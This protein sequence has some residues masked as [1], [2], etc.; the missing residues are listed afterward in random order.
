MRIA[1]SVDGR[2]ALDSFTTVFSFF[3]VAAADGE[4]PLQ[5]RTMIGTGDRLVGIGDRLLQI[6]RQTLT[7]RDDLRP[8]RDELVVPHIQRAQSFAADTASSG[9]LQQRI[10]LFEHTVVVGEDGREP[11]S[12]LD[13]ELIGEAAASRGVAAHDLQIFR[14]EQHHM[15]VAGEFVR[16]RGRAVDASLVRSLPVH[17]DL[18]E[19]ATLAVRESRADHCELL[20][21]TDHRRIRGDTVR[22]ERREENDGLGEIRLPLTV[23]PDEDVRSAMQGEFSGRVIAEIDQTQV[24]H[25]HGVSLPSGSDTGSSLVFMWGAGDDAP[26]ARRTGSLPMLIPGSPHLPK[27]LRERQG[28]GRSG[29]VSGREV[30]ERISAGAGWAE[31]GT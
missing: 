24:L 16:L 31:A 23:A 2:S 29:N 15:C 27:D 26:L 25:N 14:S 3:G 7:C 30:A 21:V 10:A 28:A 22:S 11:R 20:P 9:R 4:R 1:E 19:H 6:R 17:L 13:E 12:A 8:E 18:G 5:F